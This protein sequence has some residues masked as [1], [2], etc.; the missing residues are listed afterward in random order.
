MTCVVQHVAETTSAECGKQVQH[1]VYKERLLRKLSQCSESFYI[2]F[3]YDA[4]GQAAGGID[5]RGFCDSR[6]SSVQ[7]EPFKG[8]LATDQKLARWSTCLAANTVLSTTKRR[9]LWVLERV[10]CLV[11][12]KSMVSSGQVANTRDR[13]WLVWLLLLPV[14]SWITSY[15]DRFWVFWS[16][17]MP[18]VRSMAVWHGVVSKPA[19]KGPKRPE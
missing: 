5:R 1:H 15:T 17:L 2:A 8:R 9:W 16:T 7:A 3:K 10:C 14:T 19:E 18:L 13:V 12:D 4:G 6:K 11:F